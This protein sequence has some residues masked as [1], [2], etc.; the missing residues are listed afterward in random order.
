MNP[1]LPD[2][3]GEPVTLRRLLRTL[4]AALVWLAG[5]PWLVLSNRSPRRSTASMYHPLGDLP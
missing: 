5:I 3:G 2:I 4:M 1:V